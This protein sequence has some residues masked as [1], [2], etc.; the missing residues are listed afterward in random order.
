MF[1]FVLK[2]IGALVIFGVLVA[3][4]ALV[5]ER[6]FGSVLSRS[7]LNGLVMGAIVVV[8]G[9]LGSWLSNEYKRIKQG[10]SSGGKSPDANNP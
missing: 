4:V 5:M 1:K 2:A 7:V 8:A 10:K 9:T 3:L 6:V